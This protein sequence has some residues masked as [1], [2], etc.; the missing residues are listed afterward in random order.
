MLNVPPNIFLENKKIA[1]IYID[2][3]STHQRQQSIMGLKKKNTF[4]ILYIFT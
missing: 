1:K 2:L 4:L 3:E